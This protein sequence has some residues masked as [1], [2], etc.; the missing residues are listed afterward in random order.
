MSA[1][2]IFERIATVIV[3]V[4]DHLA[5]SFHDWWAVVVVNRRGLALILTAFTLAIFV[6]PIAWKA[7]GN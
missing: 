4:W 2:A 5:G 1:L 6:W 3:R 7:A